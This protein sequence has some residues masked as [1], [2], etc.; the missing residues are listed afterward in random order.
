MARFLTAGDVEGDGKRELV[1]AAKDTGL[2]LLRP[3]EGPKAAW[4]SEL[5]DAK[6]KGFEHAALLTDLDGDGADELYVASDDDKEIRRYAWDGQR[7]A[8]E[9]IH[10]R[11]DPLPVLT[12][13]IVSVPLS[14]VE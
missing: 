11:S 7:L 8:R 3:G 14:L 13:N 9:V 6:S 5:I 10:Q 4:R 12:W 2:W 1:V